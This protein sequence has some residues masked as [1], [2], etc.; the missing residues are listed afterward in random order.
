M[1]SQC[2][3]F[4]T[5]DANGQLCIVSYEITIYRDDPIAS[6]AGFDLAANGRSG[7][8]HDAEYWKLP[9]TTARSWQDV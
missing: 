9:W 5:E 1:I 3:G 2:V 6:E 7:T 8:F 4:P